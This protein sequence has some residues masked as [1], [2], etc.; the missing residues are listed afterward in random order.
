MKISSIMMITLIVGLIIVAFTSIVGDMQEQYP[1][2]DIN[3]S[4]W[5]NIYDTEYTD[6]L[7][8]SA[9]DLKNQFE[10][11]SDEDAWFTN[12]GQGLVAIPSV[13]LNVFQIAIKS[14]T[15][16]VAIFMN[17]G[18]IYLPTKVMVF[19]VIALLIIVVISLV[20]WWHTKAPA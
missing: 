14:M 20:N 10:E 3:Q 18:S 2:N 19:G 17:I 13:I 12:V 11:I 16:L 1:V 9:T 4:S 8:K 6:Y 15:N 7:N 5:A